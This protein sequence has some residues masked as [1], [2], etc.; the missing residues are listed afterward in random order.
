VQGAGKKYY[1]FG[2]GDFFFARRL[3]LVDHKNN[4]VFLLK[5]INAFICY[6]TQFEIYIN[7]MITTVLQ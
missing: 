7:T 3:D 6:H 4:I 1:P 5:N 2:G